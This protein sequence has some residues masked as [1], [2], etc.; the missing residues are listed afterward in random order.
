MLVIH[1]TERRTDSPSP[2]V[3][4]ATLANVGGTRSHGDYVFRVLPPAEDW[5]EAVNARPEPV[6][7]GHVK[8]FPRRS[9]RYG[10]WDLIRAAL[11]A[12]SPH[13]DVSVD[14]AEREVI[15]SVELWPFGV[16]SRRRALDFGL[17][18]GQPVLL[19]L[20]KGTKF[21]GPSSA[22]MV[23]AGS[24]V[25]QRGVLSPSTGPRGVWLT[26]RAGLNRAL[27][28]RWEASWGV[29]DR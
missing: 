6:A 13:L 9:K 29:V 18:T 21:R 28:G 14:L 11:N 1:V 12:K 7:T 5:V 16:T 15:I 25:W 2:T 8:A 22:E 26:L 24:H 3:G 19:E 27:A 10:T 17:L 23:R 20:K 4:L